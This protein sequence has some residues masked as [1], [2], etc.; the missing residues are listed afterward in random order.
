[1]LHAFVRHLHDL[2]I[3]LE[4]TIADF[5]YRKAIITYLAFWIDRIAVLTNT[6]SRWHPLDEGIKP[7]FTGQSIPMMWDYPEA[8]PF[9]GMVRF[10]S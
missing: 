4:T 9:S 10:S 6:M 1:M 2:S 8:N 3:E 5:E 7:P